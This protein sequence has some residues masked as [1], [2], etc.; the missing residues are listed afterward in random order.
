MNANNSTRKEDNV[1]PTVPPRPFR[2]F[3][4]VPRVNVPCSASATDVRQ[5]VL[6]R[7]PSPCRAAT[8]KWA[9]SLSLQPPAQPSRPHRLLSVSVSYP[10]L[11][12][13][14]NDYVITPRCSAFRCSN[15]K[16]VFHATCSRVCSRTDCVPC[17]R[18]DSVSLPASDSG[19]EDMPSTDSSCI[20]VSSSEQPLADWDRF[21][22]AYWLAVV[23]LSRF[24]ML[25]LKCKVDGSVL[26]QLAPYSP[27]LDHVADPF[28]RQALRRAILT[29]SGS[30]PT[31]GEDFPLAPRPVS[32]QFLNISRPEER[33]GLIV[34]TLEASKHDLKVTTFLREV[35]CAVCKYPLIGLLCQGYQCQVCGMIFHRVCSALDEIPVCPQRPPSSASMNLAEGNETLETLDYDCLPTVLVP[36]KSEYF[37][38]RLEDQP[39]DGDTLVPTFLVTCTSQIEQLAA[40]SLSAAIDN[41]A[42][43]PINLVTA[44]QQSALAS[45]LSEL[46]Q[47]F[48]HQLPSPGSD[49][50]AAQPLDVVR[51]AQLVKAFLRDLPSPVISEDQYPAF[52]ALGSLDEHADRKKHVHEFLNLLPRCHRACLLHVMKHLDSVWVH[53]RKL[54][55]HLD[56]EAAQVCSENS[57]GDAPADRSAT[58]LQRLCKPVN[59]LLVFRQILI[60]PPWNLLTDIATA[61]D[62]HLRALETVFLV[63]STSASDQ[64]SHSLPAPLSVYR[65]NSGIAPSSQPISGSPYEYGVVD[66]TGL[67]LPGDRLH[68]PTVNTPPSAASRDEN[69]RDLLSREWYWGDVTQA[70]VR[71]IM[72]G[73]PDGYFLVRDASEQSAGAFTLAVRWHGEN[74][75]YRIYHRGDYFGLTDPPQ[76]VFRL[77]SEL[78]GFYSSHARQ[79]GEQLGLQ[80]LWPVSR[81]YNLFSDT[82]QQQSVPIQLRSPEAKAVFACSLPKDQLLAQL[83]RTD[84][85]LVTCEQLVKELSAQAQRT[86]EGK[87]ESARLI[88]GNQKLQEWLRRQQS[89]LD[90]YA[91]ADDIPSLARQHEI[92]RERIRDAKRQVDRNTERHLIQSTQSRRIIENQVHNMGR[93]TKLK[94]QAQEIRRALKDL[95]VG[96]EALMDRAVS[97]PAAGDT[98]FDESTV[99]NSQSRSSVQ[100]S[101][102][103]SARLSTSDEAS[104]PNIDSRANWFV[105]NIT[106]EEV[107]RVLADKP[108]GTFLI[109][110]ATDGHRLALGVRLDSSVQHCLIHHVNGRYGFVEKSCVFD[111]LEALVRHY[112]VYSLKQ[113]NALLNTTLRYP[114]NSTIL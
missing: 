64:A 4:F 70:E 30:Q 104:S 47:T 38:V 43:R 34:Q 42:A 1:P 54:K 39:F 85:E 53:Q 103:V 61:L 99:D 9:S 69:A 106:R 17:N 41:P 13:L 97:S 20:F 102:R 88:K 75:L 105:P 93:R 2:S 95:G 62:V 49:Q 65:R 59:W 7:E 73:L 96:E 113:H 46:H 89:L 27:Q 60:R 110:L 58:Q 63:L 36:Y 86:M 82:E 35:A 57:A 55:N 78:V 76:P 94:R 19:P 16:V 51:L 101:P 6:S 24:V 74:K 98:S 22:V 15:C 108:T 33:E 14:C 11:C 90:Q 10:R 32:A 109:R 100:K 66:A 12:A 23:G 72:A 37:G 67:S 29:L 84:T 68:C 80:L 5:S 52:C 25:F 8:Q 71:E 81:R 111:S 114:V 91:T 107:E 44:Y 40:E 18:A 112:H 3:G 48:A 79:P 21:Q 26:L 83:H 87:E 56:L 31:A 28:S 77:V 50:L 92:L 45:T